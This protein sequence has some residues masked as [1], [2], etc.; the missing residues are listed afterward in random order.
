MAR[1]VKRIAAQ[2]DL[3]SIAA[4][5]QAMASP[6]VAIRF[7]DASN[8]D[9]VRLSKMSG[10][11]SRFESDHPALEGLRVWPIRGFRKYLILYRPLDDGIEVVRVLHGSRDIERLLEP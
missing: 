1:V 8:R 4:S 6:L 7:L 9:F 10:L 3:D 2:R 11:G 5:L